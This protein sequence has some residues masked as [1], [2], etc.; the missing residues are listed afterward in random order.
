VTGVNEIAELLL[1]SSAHGE[2]HR[3]LLGPLSEALLREKGTDGVD[4]CVRDG[5]EYVCVA[6]RREAAAG[7]RVARGSCRTADD[8]PC[9]AM[10]AGLACPR[11]VARGREAELA[12][13]K[14]RHAE[15]L[16]TV[17]GLASGVG[18]ELAEPLTAIV[19]F[20]EL[21]RKEPGLSEQGRRDLERIE[22]A[23]QHAK[24]IVRRLMSF[25]T[26][27]PVG[28]QELDLNRVVDDALALVRQ[29]C[30]TGR[31][32]LVLDLEPG[33][34][35][36]VGDATQLCQV[37]VNLARNSLQALPQGGTLK[38]RTRARSRAL[39]LRVEDDGVGMSDE[40]RARIFEPFFTTKSARGG[41]GLGLAIVHDVVGLHGGSIEVESAPGVGTCVTVRLPLGS[42]EARVSREEGPGGRRS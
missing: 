2:P 16:S 7:A 11:Q 6:A 1:R 5:D 3:A 35:A 21:L 40:V 15:R 32:E 38:V 41:M 23:S 12:S 33:L 20:A 24:E 27:S 10:N 13:R 14:L 25:G 28:W 19:G 36:L 22:T 30:R 17:G 8:V 42:P 37:L 4:L 31:V 18:H 29:R 34:P 39:E 26:R 9:D